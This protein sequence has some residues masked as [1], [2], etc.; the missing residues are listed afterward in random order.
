MA[1]GALALALGLP[2]QAERPGVLVR[3]SHVVAADTPKGRMAQ[4][5]KKLVEERGKGRLRVEVY[6]DSQLYGDEDEMEAL[7]LGAV[8]LLAPSLS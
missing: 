8:E 3:F 1:L 5:F 6:P 2:A 7:R 4:H